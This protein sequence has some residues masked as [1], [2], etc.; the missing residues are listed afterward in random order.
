MGPWVDQS[1]LTQYIDQV[2]EFITDDTQDEDL[3]RIMN[4]QKIPREYQETI[5]SDLGLS[6]KPVEAKKMSLSPEQWDLLK[7]MEREGSVKKILIMKTPHAS[8]TLKALLGKDLIAQPNDSEFILNERGK[9]LC[10][11]TPRWSGSTTTEFNR[12][13]QVWNL[14]DLGTSFSD[15]SP[16]RAR[17]DAKVDLNG[18]HERTNFFSDRKFESRLLMQ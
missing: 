1:K 12:G 6:L 5:A 18:D 3:Q 10:A 4:E 2:M 9:G 13:V 16:N 17:P 7:K 11:M 14:Y 8:R 15:F